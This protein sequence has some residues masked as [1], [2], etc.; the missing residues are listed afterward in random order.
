MRVASYCWAVDASVV[1]GTVWLTWLVTGASVLAVGAAFVGQW[2]LGRL[3]ARIAVLGFL[4]FPLLAFF[5]VDGV[6]NAD[7]SHRATALAKQVSEVVNC[8]AFA[9]ICALV[10]ATVWIAA[11]R[12]ERKLRA[13]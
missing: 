8:G 7:G 11:S 13:A 5:M 4:A 9:G 1:E 6:A 10:A 3:A 12:H 2:T